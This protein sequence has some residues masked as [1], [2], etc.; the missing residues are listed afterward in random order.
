MRIWV[1]PVGHGDRAAAGRPQSGR[2]QDDADRAGLRDGHVD[3]DR[4]EAEATDYSGD[5]GGE[6]RPGVV[7]AMEPADDLVE[8]TQRLGID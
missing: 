2:R 5:F 1:Q 4:R 8:G 3:R 6:R 7:S